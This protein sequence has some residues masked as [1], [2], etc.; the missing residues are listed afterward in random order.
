MQCDAALRATPHAVRTV[1]GRLV[2]YFAR[3]D[4]SKCSRNKRT[5]RF[6]QIAV[7]QTN[8]CDCAWRCAHKARH[9]QLRRMYESDEAYTW[10]QRTTTCCDPVATSRSWIEASDFRDAAS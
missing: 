4:H 1:Q 5:D 7:R 9:R 8:R 2:H 6:H 10:L 3:K